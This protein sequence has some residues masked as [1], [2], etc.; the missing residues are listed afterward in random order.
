VSAPHVTRGSRGQSFGGGDSPGDGRAGFGKSS[1][2]NTPSY[3]R[4]TLLE[5]RNLDQ[6]IADIGDASTFATQFA[7][8][9]VKVPDC[10]CRTR[11]VVAIGA[12]PGAAIF[13]PNNAEHTVLTNTQTATLWMALRTRIDDAGGARYTPTRNLVGTGLAPLAIPTDTR[14]WGWETEIETIGD[15]IWGVLQVTG[16][17]IASSPYQWHVQV[18]FNAVGSELTTDEWEKFMTKKGIV[19]ADPIRAGF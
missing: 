15:D 16:G 3:Q 12:G 10:R 5:D 4:V 18:G 14:L 17:A 1:N 7:R 19:R 9:Q 6:I 11:V 8:F 13:D 2:P